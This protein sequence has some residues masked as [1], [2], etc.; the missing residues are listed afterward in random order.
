[1]LQPDQALLIV[2]DVQE[3]LFRTIHEA[4]AMVDKVCRLVRGCG[5]LGVPVRHT[6]Q[7]PSG[8]GPT[9]PEV[10]VLIRDD[11][12]V[13]FSFSCY[14]EPTFMQTVSTF[15]R[16]QILL[17][18]IEAHVCVYQTAADLAI[19]GYE[20]QVVTDA[21]SSRNPADKAVGLAKMTATGC[22]L[23]SVE[24]AL[25]EMLKVAS[26]RQFKEILQIVK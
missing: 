8:L 17:V 18:G 9:V 12:I 16:K 26:G 22:Q 7:N 11:P 3:K 5:V 15:E 6:E 24:T 2:V 20:V 1:M 23:T 10:A 4:D 25:F 19:A 21:V 14:R 13:K